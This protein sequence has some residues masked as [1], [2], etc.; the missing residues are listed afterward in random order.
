MTEKRVIWQETTLMCDSCHRES[1]V[2]PVDE[3]LI[4]KQCPWCGANMLSQEDYDSFYRKQ[5]RI[6]DFINKWFKWVPGWA[7]TY[8]ESLRGAAVSVRRKDGDNE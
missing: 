1:Q 3:N 6:V 2:Y 5:K 4:G 7:C 8:E